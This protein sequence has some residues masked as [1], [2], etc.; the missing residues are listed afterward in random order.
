M[1]DGAEVVKLFGETIDVEAEIVRLDGLSGH[2]DREGL[3]TWINAF[4]KKPGRVFMVHG[5]DLVCTK[6]ANLLRSDYDL[7]ADAPFSGSEFDLAAG[8]WLKQTVGVPI[9]KETARQKENKSIFALLVAAGERLVRIIQKNRDCA[10]KD[11]KK[12]TA[13]VNALCEKWDL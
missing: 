6:F 7:V 4:K 10:N 1:Y 9:Q 3:L 2:A 12:F 8:V 5:D 11:I 13:E